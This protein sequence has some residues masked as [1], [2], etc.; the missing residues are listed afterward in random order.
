MNVSMTRTTAF[1]CWCALVLP[2]ATS[3][4]DY[5]VNCKHPKASDEN[6]GA[7]DEPWKTTSTPQPSL[8]RETRFM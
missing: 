6:S 1:L 8:C 3:G 7:A 4:R 2:A 5:Y